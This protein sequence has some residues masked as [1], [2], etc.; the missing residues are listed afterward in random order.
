MHRMGSLA[1]VRAPSFA[2]RL[3]DFRWINL[4]ALVVPEPPI[5]YLDR[6]TSPAI[7]LPSGMFLWGVMVGDQIGGSSAKR[8]T[9]KQPSETLATP[10]FRRSP[11]NVATSLS[12]QC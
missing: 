11:G 5:K 10:I 12:Q 1:L 3:S 9:A 8:T 2:R 4:D 6:P 7:P